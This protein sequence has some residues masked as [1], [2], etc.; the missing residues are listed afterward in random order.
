MHT[1]MKLSSQI[2][3]KDIHYF[4]KTPCVM[5]LNFKDQ[6]LNWIWSFWNWLSNMLIFGTIRI[7]FSVVNR[8]LIIRAKVQQ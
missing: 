1:H 2:K 5:K 7:L 3:I 8:L 4:K 6:F